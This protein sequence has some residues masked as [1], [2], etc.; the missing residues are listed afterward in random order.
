[1]F[2]SF[3]DKQSFDR[4]IID[5]DSKNISRLPKLTCI[6][7]TC[8]FRI[9]RSSSAWKGCNSS[10]GARVVVTS[11]QEQ[12]W[13]PHW[14]HELDF[15]PCIRPCLISICFASQIRAS[16]TNQANYFELLIATVT[17][18]LIGQKLT[19][20][21]KWS[22]IQRKQQTKACS[23][24]DSRAKFYSRSRKSTEQNILP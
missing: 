9:S 2:Y 1:M 5:W 12:H 15:S 14:R 4:Y 20:R 3:T 22:D 16:R 8:C 19:L 10:R 11:A 7:D 23:C 17:L 6:K 13:N 18:R 24:F 21:G